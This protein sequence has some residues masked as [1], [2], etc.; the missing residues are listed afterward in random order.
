MQLAHPYQFCVAG[1]YHKNTV[2]MTADAI[3]VLRGKIADPPEQTVERAR[4]LSGNCGQMVAA[5]DY[6]HR[7]GRPTWT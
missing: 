4:E 7:H 5:N 6:T 1:F 3:G 2:V